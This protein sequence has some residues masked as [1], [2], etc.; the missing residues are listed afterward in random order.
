MKN[1]KFE[2]IFIFLISVIALSKFFEAGRLISSEMSFINLGISVIALLIF[3]FT[4]SVM[5]YWV[6]E[7][8][9]QK[10]NLKIKFSLYEWMYEKRNGEIANKQ[11]GEEK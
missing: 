2:R 6:Y 8:E 3:V 4:L 11:W 1:I 10:N 9:K 7:E 5:G